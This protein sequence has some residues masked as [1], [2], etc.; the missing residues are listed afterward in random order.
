MQLHDRKEHKMSKYNI[1]KILSDGS[2]MLAMTA[3]A[4]TLKEARQKAIN[5]YKWN[6]WLNENNII[7]KKASIYV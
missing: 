4:N 2:T 3:Y 7:V 6:N 1:F 5:T